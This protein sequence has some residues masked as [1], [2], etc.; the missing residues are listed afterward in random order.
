MEFM[1]RAI[2]LAGIYFTTGVRWFFLILSIFIL[3]RQI[4]SLLQAR[5]PSEIW[6]YLGCPDDTTVPLTHWE[7]L[8]G[9]SRGCDVILNLN[10]VSR[11][12]GTL[13][14]DSDGVWKYND[15]N[16]KNG[17][18]INGV[19]VKEPTILKAGDVLT[20]GGSDFTL[21]PVSLE[22]D[23][24][25]QLPFAVGLLCILMWTYV[26][27]MRFFKRVGFEMEIIAFYLS[28]LSLAVTAS[29][30]PSTVLKQ[31]ICICLGVGLFF[32]LCWFLRDLNRAKRIVYIMMGI[33][34]LLLIINL[35]FGTT[36]YGASNWVSIGGMSI[37]PSELVKIVFIYVGAATLDE[38]QQRKNLLIFM[39]FSVFCLGCLAL[40]GDFGTALIFFVTFL[41]ISFLRSGDFSKIILILGASGLMGM[42][43]L[44]FK[45]YISKRFDTWGHVWD[46]PTGDGFQQVQTMTA[47][48][49]GGLPGLGA[50]NGKFSQ[51]AA[52]P[53]DLVF[54]LLSEEWGLII[55]IL[56]VL[57]II[58]LGVFAVRSIIAGRSTYYSI[59]ACA[60]TSMFIFQTILNVFGS[61]DLLP[62][63]GVTFPFVS[64]GGTSML[65]SWGLLSFLKAADTRQNASFAIRLD[66]KGEFD[67]ELEGG[68]L[69]NPED[70]FAAVDGNR[71]GYQENRN[72]RNYDHTRATGTSGRSG[73]PGRSGTSGRFDTP[74]R[75]GTSGRPGTPGSPGK[76]SHGIRNR[77][78]D[79]TI[80]SSTS[81]RPKRQVKYENIS[82]DEFFNN[83]DSI[84]PGDSFSERYDRVSP[85]PSSA[86]KPQGRTSSSGRSGQSRTARPQAQKPQR[87]AGRSSTVRQSASGSQTSRTQPRPQT[88]RTRP[89]QQEESQ[90]LTLE[91]I[92]G[93]DKK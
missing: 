68:G 1:S 69:E 20:I 35:A 10:S 24:P 6:A 42:M 59:A 93:G 11:S 53:T 73:T 21:Y 40:M 78:D 25:P 17:S 28:T 45:P 38:L 39:G 43:V 75:S 13:I 51:V 92:F 79:T 47:S 61:V 84:R 8:I 87:P 4:R 58:T 49:S 74:G 65:A 22:E 7:N 23:F 3:A 85:T 19:P 14:R 15:L 70:I 77:N 72:Y 50:G 81:S 57:C 37:Q 55:A 5:N 46:D 64:S 91:D 36:K 56:A 18:A 66:K 31:S 30:Y 62:L 44:R 29:A 67:N 82:D 2:E 63:T 27:I 48:A 34:V 76:R 83:L 16:S 71:G 32:G 54:G 52:A 60:A 33:S 12:H 89:K 26:I 88:S 41:V 86:K 80:I 9:R 90:P